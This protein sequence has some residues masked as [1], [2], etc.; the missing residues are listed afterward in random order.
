MFKT[1]ESLFETGN[2]SIFCSGIGAVQ[3]ISSIQ[4][5][6][7]C[8]V[9]DEYH[10]V[11]LPI[12]NSDQR[13]TN[14][15]YITK[16]SAF[17]SIPTATVSSLHNEFSATEDGRRLRIKSES[18]VMSPSQITITA[19]SIFHCPSTSCNED[20]LDTCKTLLWDKIHW[21]AFTDVTYSEQVRTLCR[22]VQQQIISEVM[23]GIHGAMA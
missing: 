14:V 15:L 6:S 5:S 7:V 3:S 4:L 11:I 1:K 13:H 23:N 20:W 17:L 22:V 12:I 9:V 2:S 18:H 10:H 8:P 21:T 16:L 19:S